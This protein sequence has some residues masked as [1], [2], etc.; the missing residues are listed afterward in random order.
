MRLLA[1]LGATAMLAG[2]L[3][4]PG[5]S[6][7]FEAN[8]Q[9][10]GVIENIVDGLIGNRYGSDRQA[11]RACAWASVSKAER[12]YRRY[13]NGRPHAYPGYRGYVR[14]AAITDVQRRILGVRVRGLLDTSRY[15]YG[16]GRHGAD[17]QF[18][19]DATRGGH[20]TDVRL[21]RNPGYR[22]R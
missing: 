6:Q 3:A 2:G 20:V 16:G 14:V 8:A 10:Q 22:P 5:N 9:A 4:A 18:R 13:F 15:G 11:I 17:L 19:C 1:Y 21:E 12:D 7:E